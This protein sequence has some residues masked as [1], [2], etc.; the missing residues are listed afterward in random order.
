MDNYSWLQDSKS[1]K[2]TCK[3][4]KRVQIIYLASR[5][6]SHVRDGSMIEGK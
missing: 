5:K 3:L 6:K 1:R 4:R 2:Q